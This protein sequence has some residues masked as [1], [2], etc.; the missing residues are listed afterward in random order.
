MIALLNCRVNNTVSKAHELDANGNTTNDGV[1]DFTYNQNQRLITA[2]VGNDTV[3]EYKYDGNGRRI[4]KT[5]GGTTTV[6]H[7]DLNSALIGE[8]TATGTPVVDYVYLNGAPL[9]QLRDGAVYYYHNDH[10]MT[11]KVMTGAN[12]AVVWNVEFDPFG[13][14]VPGTYTRTVENNL[15]FPGQYFDAE[16][17]INHNGHRD[18]DSSTGRYVEADPIGLRGGRNLYGYSLNNAVR[19]YDALGLV[20]DGGANAGIWG[21]HGSAPEIRN[22]EPAWGP[23]IPCKGGCH[24]AGDR[25]PQPGQPCIKCD[26]NAVMKCWISKLAHQSLGSV[27]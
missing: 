25:K 2:K 12:K 4:I 24:P 23:R 11:P 9:A 7:Y 5:A 13:N 26:E 8:S 16:T 14:E 17:G 6:Y 3:G 10:L 19:Y 27:N 18:Y 21:P 20:P 22:P 1:H 15:R